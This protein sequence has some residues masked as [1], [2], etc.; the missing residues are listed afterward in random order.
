MAK[1][2]I[3]GIMLQWLGQ[4]HR[5][6]RPRG[7]EPLA[8]DNNNTTNNETFTNSTN[9]SEYLSCCQPFYREIA[10]TLIDRDER[11]DMKTVLK[12]LDIGLPIQ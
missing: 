9:A 2:E 3:T 4:Q 1:G 5:H 11:T 12:R 10:P 6:R 8:V 7:Q